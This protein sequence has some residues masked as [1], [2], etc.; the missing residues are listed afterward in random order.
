M[1]DILPPTEEDGEPLLSYEEWKSKK[2]RET[3]ELEEK[4]LEGEWVM[5]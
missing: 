5:S 3:Q 2:M 4:E 1:D